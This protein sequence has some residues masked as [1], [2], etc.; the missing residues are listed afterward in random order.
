[1]CT[2]FPQLLQGGH[3]PEWLVEDDEGERVGAAEGVGTVL[4]FGPGL[5]DAG[6]VP[7]YRVGHDTSCM[8]GSARGR[9]GGRRDG[10]TGE[11]R[12]GDEPGSKMRG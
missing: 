4:P 2:V 12:P 6:R 1:M 11:T 8:H 10:E 5:E 3:V 9:G 7:L